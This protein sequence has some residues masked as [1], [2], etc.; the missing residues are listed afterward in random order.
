M[1]TTLWGRGTTVMRTAS[2]EARAK[3]V[4]FHKFRYLSLLECRHSTLGKMF[5]P[6]HFSGILSTIV[7]VNGNPFL[8]LE[9][10]YVWG[11]AGRTLG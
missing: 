1:K 9:G 7:T 6:F 11:G 5:Q 10:T 4:M 3:F 8:H 2:T